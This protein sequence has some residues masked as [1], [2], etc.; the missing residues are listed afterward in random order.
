MQKQSKKILIVEDEQDIRQKLAAKCDNEGFITF[1][2][3]NGEEGLSLALREHP[4]LIL[5]DLAMPKMDGVEMLK[6]LRQD[7][8]GQNATVVVLTNYSNPERVA[9]VLEAGV[10]DYIMKSDRL[11]DIMEHI[12]RRLEPN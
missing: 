4:D 1:Q 7:E 11:E 9:N 5:L 12:K 10:H 3:Q 6:Q 2:A 8:W